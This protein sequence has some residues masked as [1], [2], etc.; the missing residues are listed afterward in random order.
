MHWFLAPAMSGTTGSPHDSVLSSVQQNPLSTFKS[1]ANL[2]SHPRCF[3][4]W[5]S[6]ASCFLVIWN[7]YWKHIPRC[8]RPWV[9]YMFPPEE[10]VSDSVT[11]KSKLTGSE[12]WHVVMSTMLGQGGT[13]DRCRGD[14]QGTQHLLD[15]PPWMDSWNSVLHSDNLKSGKQATSFVP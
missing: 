5:H 4:S 1:N 14:T 15:N 12:R 3:H 7:H 13:G 10:H 6:Q 2:V 8:P 9:L 11:N